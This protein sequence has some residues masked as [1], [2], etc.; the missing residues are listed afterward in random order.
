MN[1]H[2][3]NSNNPGDQPLRDQPTGDQ[4]TGNQPPRDWTN[5]DLSRLLGAALQ[6]KPGANDPMKKL[7]RNLGY[8]AATAAI[9][10]VLYGVTLCLYPIWPVNLCLIVL[11]V[12]TGW[13]V[14]S[15]LRLRGKVA[16]PDSPVA[17]LQEMLRYQRHISRWLRLQQ[18]VG[19][20]VYPF[21]IVGGG[22][23]GAYLV[24]NETMDSLLRDKVLDTL[25]IVLVILL[26][27]CTLLLGRALGHRAYGRYLTDLQKNIDELRSDLDNGVAGT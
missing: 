23:M 18:Y 11:L 9:L 2:P 21:S 7:R 12:F 22:L 24:G 27:P 17:L 19:I 16:P 8:S 5:E 20:V 6:K 10:E 3:A 1:T 25:L 4:P 26:V 13:G 14:F 15:A